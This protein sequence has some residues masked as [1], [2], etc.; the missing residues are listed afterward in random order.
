MENLSSEEGLRRASHEESSTH[1]N[2]TN[3][4][5]RESVEPRVDHW[6][7]VSLMREFGFTDINE[8]PLITEDPRIKEMRAQ[9]FVYGTEVNDNGE[10]ITTIWKDGYCWARKGSAPQIE[11]IEER[12]GRTLRRGAIQPSDLVFEHTDLD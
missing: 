6:E 10:T 1:E 8:N 3:E 4:S 2:E 9:D 5:P 11:R 7:M 12:L